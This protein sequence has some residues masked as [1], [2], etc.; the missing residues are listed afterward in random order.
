[1][2][3]TPD[4]FL[5]PDEAFERQRALLSNRVARQAGPTPRRRGPLAAGVALTA[6]VTVLLVTPAFGVG[7]KLLDSIRGNP[8]PAE[9]KA[10]FASSD[11]SRQKFLGLAHEAGQRLHERY[12]PVLADETRGLF[13][14]ETPDGSIYLWAAPTQD[15]RQ[16]WMIQTSPRPGG[17]GSCD[18]I[19]DE[20]PI[21]PEILGAPLDQPG[22]K[23]LHARLLDPSIT[24]VI[25]ETEG[26]GA[27]SLHVVDG[28]VL[29]TV[30]QDAKVLAVVG[31]NA[32][33]EEVA[34][35]SLG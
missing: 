22:V 31:R 5:L 33:D 9:V 29:G 25:F 32:G 19:G 34:R 13:S 26:S 30:Q 24:R 10:S 2:I 11:Q 4:E 21:R 20:R 23:I 27:V 7:G 17:V 35:M 14:I 28:H 18:G 8:A 12:S 16:C 6:L 1:M 3:E 15:G